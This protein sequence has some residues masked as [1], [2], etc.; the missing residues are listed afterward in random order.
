MVCRKELAELDVG[1]STSIH[2]RSRAVTHQTHD[3]PPRLQVSTS[4]T[5]STETH[6]LQTGQEDVGGDEDVSAA[7]TE[8]AAAA[9]HSAARNTRQDPEQFTAAGQHNG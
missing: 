7:G 9:G 5:H 8:R 3:R 1:G 2:R 6:R 4:Q